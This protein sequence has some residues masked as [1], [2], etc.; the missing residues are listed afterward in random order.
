MVVSRSGLYTICMFRLTAGP[1]V[2]ATEHL[3]DVNKIQI[4]G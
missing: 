3:E 2:A 1:D 4:D